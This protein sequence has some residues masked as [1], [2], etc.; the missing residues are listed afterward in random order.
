MSNLV[1]PSCWYITTIMLA[2]AV[3]CSYTEPS[4]NFSV[5]KT[6][7]LTSAQAPDSELIKKAKS[8]FNNLVALDWNYDSAMFDLYADDALIQN[9]RRYPDGRTKVLNF[10]R[11]I[12]GYEV[13]VISDAMS[14]LWLN[15]Y[16][17]ER[18]Q[19]R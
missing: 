2:L 11:C 15:S 7:A 6:S 14:A 9:T 13:R 12:I 16:P 8:F 19:A 17:Q 4:K 5:S 3:G 10:W 18:D 1:K